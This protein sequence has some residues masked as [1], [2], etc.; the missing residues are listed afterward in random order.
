MS[1]SVIAI[2]IALAQI[3][4]VVVGEI[5]VQR[6]LSKHNENLNNN[7]ID[8]YI[9][10]IKD[11]PYEEFQVVSTC[12]IVEKEFKTAYMDKNILLKTLEEHGVSELEENYNKISGCIGNFTLNFERNSEN[13]AFVLKI[14][15][16]ESDNAEEKLTD[17]NS[18][19]ALNVQED[20]YLHL[21]DKLKE[22]NMEIEE[23][24][25]EEDN[26]IVL[27]INLE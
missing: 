27:T 13:E 21:L 1:C 8:E 15:C 19:Y 26:T 24:V 23:E 12:D 18:E 3:I 6:A 10:N 4:S 25:V 16:K 2:P 11:N 20:A 5:A 9:Q 14:S 17:L 22:N 7:Q